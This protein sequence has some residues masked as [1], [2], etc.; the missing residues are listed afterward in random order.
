MGPSV[1][2]GGNTLGSVS[3]PA[4]R[5][6]RDWEDVEELRAELSEAAG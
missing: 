3:I 4:M 6:L 2:F 1:V 5:R